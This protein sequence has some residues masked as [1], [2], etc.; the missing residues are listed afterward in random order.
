MKKILFSLLFVLPFTG[1][2]QDKFEIKG[3]L[4]GIGAGKIAVLSYKNSMGKS[5]NDTAAVR[6]GQF[7]FNGETAFGNRSYLAVYP[8]KK[9]SLKSTRQADF[10][11]FYLEKGKYLV[12]GTD[13]MKN[14]RITGAQAQADFLLFN[15]IMDTMT[16]HYKVLTDRYLKA[17][18]AKDDAAMKQVQAEGRPL[19]INMNKAT[20]AFIFSH[21]D[22][23]VTLDIIANEKSAVIDPKVFDPY[24]KSLSPRV[25]GSATGKAL[26]AKYAKAMQLSLGKILDFTQMDNKG[27]EFKLSSLKGKYVLVDFWASW[28][29]PC[30]AENPHLLKAYTALKN[31]NFEIVGI[32]LDEAKANWLRAVDMDGMPWIQV[33]DLK[34]FQNDVA[35]KFGITA[36]PQNVLI[37]PQ[38]VIIA[39]NLRGEDVLDQLSKYVK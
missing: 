23:Y 11:A 35:T 30:R 13:S 28:C 10:Q 18:S 27:N 16:T 29:V 3:K 26:A 24:Y 19:G 38:G 31:K 37:D 4:S 7:K 21:P 6:D 8:L 15:S 36:I 17:R 9:D 33:S 20:D 22:S 2:A 1:I 39:K 12:T 25:M 34:G 32:S 5:K 14:A